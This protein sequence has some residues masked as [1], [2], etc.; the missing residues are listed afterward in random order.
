[1]TTERIAA[2]LNSK[3]NGSWFNME[4]NSELPI[5][6]DAKRRG[7]VAYK[8]TSAQVRKGIA[9][10]N[11]KSV[12]Q[13]VENGKI[14][15]HELPWGKWKDGKEG[16]FIEHKGTDYVRLYFGPNGTKTHYFVDGVEVT[17]E[18][19]R[20]MAI[21]KDSYFK[22]KEK[23]DCITVKCSNINIIG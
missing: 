18:E 17:Y 3:T 23:A 4:W 12:R 16:L 15:T 10:A 22:P 21:V 7:T 20:K 11:Q 13:K 8:T 2:I 5:T 14:L 1:M 9:Y 6:A 19:L